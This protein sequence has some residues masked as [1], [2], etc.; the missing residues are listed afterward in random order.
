MLSWLRGALPDKL[1][2]SDDRQ[3]IATASEELGSIV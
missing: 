2:V 3:R 1:V